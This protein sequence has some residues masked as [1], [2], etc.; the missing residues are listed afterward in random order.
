MAVPPVRKTNRSFDG[1]TQNEVIIFLCQS[2]KNG[3]KSGVAV[4]VLNWLRE[5][6]NNS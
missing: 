4:Q 2:Q 3:N 6:T 5:I 1:G